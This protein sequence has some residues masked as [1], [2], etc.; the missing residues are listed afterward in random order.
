[1][2]TT[3]SGAASLAR[4]EG[5]RRSPCWLTMAPGGVLAAQ[6]GPTLSVM[7]TS[8]TRWTYWTRITL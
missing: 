6:I 7:K 5:R 1:M 4:D 8:S 3:H 2:F